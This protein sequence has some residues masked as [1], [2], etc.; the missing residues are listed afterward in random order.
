MYARLMKTN[1]F[2]A[3]P[4]PLT[5]LD[6]HL[7]EQL[8]ALG[9]TSSQLIAALHETFRRETGVDAPQDAEEFVPIDSPINSPDWPAP[10]LQERAR[11][12]DPRTGGSCNAAWGEWISP[13]Q[14]QVN[15]ATCWYPLPQDDFVPDW[16]MRAAWPEFADIWEDLLEDAWA[17]H[18]LMRRAVEARNP[19]PSMIDDDL[20]F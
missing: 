10:T 9:A 4:E 1:E 3:A 7:V 18:Q 12:I 6:L 17:R 2:Q 8:L 5:E 19:S 16:Q 11:R 13:W 15:L 20:P 14:R